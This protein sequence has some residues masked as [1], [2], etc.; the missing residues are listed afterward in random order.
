MEET[1]ENHI[2]SK[3]NVEIPM[4]K[5]KNDVKL[6]K[7][8]QCNF[9]SSKKGNLKVHMKTHSDKKSNKCYQCNFDFDG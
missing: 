7:C 8:N 4:K 2:L 5:T 1:L 9:A 6:N 3:Q